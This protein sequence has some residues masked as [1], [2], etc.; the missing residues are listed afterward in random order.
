MGQLV[1]FTATITSR[2][3]G[4]S[5]GTGTFFVGS[6]TLGIAAVGGNAAS[7]TTSGL[8]VGTHSI[9]AIYSCDSNFTGS[10]SNPLLQVVT[11]ATTTTSVASSVNPSVQG[12]TRPIFC[13]WRSL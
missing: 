3:G 1:L 6:T 5:S 12:M 8:A 10:T 9:T 13:L 4:Q 11:K 2:Y 7:L